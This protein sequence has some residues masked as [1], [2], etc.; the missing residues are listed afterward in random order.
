MKEQND[1]RIFT[2]VA[3]SL[4]VMWTWSYFF[5]PPPPEQSAAAVVEGAAA[6]G[7]AAAGAVP[8]SA[9]PAPSAPVASEAPCTGK[10]AVLESATAALEVSD[11]GAIRSVRFPG[12]G[13]PKVVTGWWSWAWGRATGSESGGWVPYA[14]GDHDLDL[15]T[16]GELLA[17]GR[18]PY[19]FGGTWTITS[20]DPLVQERRTADGFRVVRTITRG[21]SPDLWNVRIH[22]E[23]DRPLLGPFWVGSADQFGTFSAYSTAPT[24][25]NWTEGDWDAEHLA[26]GADFSAPKVWDGPAGWSGVGDRFYLVAAAPDDPAA[27]SRAE[28][29]RLDAD[30]VGSFYVLAAPSL[31][32]GAP[33]DVSFTVYAGPRELAR[34]EAAGHGFEEAVSLGWFGLFA[35][36]LLVTLHLI[37]SVVGDWGYSILALTLLVRVVTYPLTRQAVVS[38]RRMQALQPLMKELQEKYADDKETLN[39]E[40]MAL[41]GKHGVNPLGGCFPMLVQM[42]VFIALFTALQYEPSLFNQQ[43]FYVQDLSAQDPY[44][45]LSLF[46]VV[47]MYVQ[48]TMMPTTGMDPTQ[49]QMLKLMPLFFGLMMW[50]SPAGLALY[51]SLNTVLAI[52]Q[53]WY[54]TRSIP[55]AVLDGDANVPS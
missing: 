3:V 38:G 34:L 35:K 17:A 27:A 29:A 43:F 36:F 32:P 12:V 11:C 52:V 20:T 48:Q 54:N 7:T 47:G 21:A 40:M 2:F 14:G 23:S 44:G 4:A 9:T 22:M 39:R 24:L 30:R 41:Y 13:A 51:Y 1:R 6:E 49:A 46:V 50:S 10:S 28:W 8:A 33:I 45:F 53:Q 19:A 25:L 42:P 18:G 55:P 31:A 37:Q 5:A 15:L 16:K 26:S